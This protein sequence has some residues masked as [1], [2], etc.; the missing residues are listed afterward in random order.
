MEQILNSPELMA[1]TENIRRFISEG[2]YMPV[3]KPIN[4]W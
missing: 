2:E 3:S 1:R 4:N